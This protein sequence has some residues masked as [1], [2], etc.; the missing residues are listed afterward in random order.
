MDGHIW[1]WAEK[2]TVGIRTR[3]RSAVGPHQQWHLVMVQLQGRPD[4]GEAE[5][6]LPPGFRATGGLCSNNTIR[7]NTTIQYNTYNTLLP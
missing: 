3:V 1:I 2:Y 4:R 7:I 6:R 5:R